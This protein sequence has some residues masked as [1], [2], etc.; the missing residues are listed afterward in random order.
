M[1]S[2]A[3]D[4]IGGYNRFISDQRKNGNDAKVTLVQFDSEDSHEVVY[5][6]IP[7]SEVKKL[8]KTTFIPRSSTPLL[9]A[10]GLL[11]AKIREQRARATEATDQLDD[12]VFVT[13]TDG[14]ENSS[15][16]YSLPR[17]RDLIANCEAEG[18]TFV[19]LSAGIDAYGDAGDLGM[20]AGRTRAF[21]ANKTGA[22]A[23]FDALSTNMVL[24]R[25]KKRRGLNTSADDFFDEEKVDRFLGEE[26]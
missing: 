16:E 24:L 23:M 14:E 7:V 1:E 26:E 25:D 2:I 17:V 12:I 3:N 22:E 19:F 13:I 15:S 5:E 4:V 10:T 6:S 20:Q 8:T 11:V 9:D 18:W 21:R